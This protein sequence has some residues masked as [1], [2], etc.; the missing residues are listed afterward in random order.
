MSKKELGVL[1]DSGR[2]HWKKEEI[3]ALL[4]LIKEKGFN[5]FQWHFSDFLGFRVKLDSFPEIASD[6]HLSKEEMREI[7]TYAE[8]LGID[9]VPEFDT[10]G[11][12]TPMLAKYPTWGVKQID[13]NGEVKHSDTALD[14][15]NP[16]AKQAV[17]T[18]LE[19]ILTLFPNSTHFHLGADEFIWFSKVQE[20][21]DLISSSQALVGEV[22][23]GLESY[24]AY[25]NE[26]ID[27]MNER[28]KTPRVWNDGFFRSDVVSKVEL[29]KNVEICYWTKWDEAMATLDTWLE[30]GYKMLNYN[31]NY[32]YYVLGEHSSYTYPT[33]EKVREGWE[34]YKFSGEQMVPDAHKHQLVGTYLA[35]WSDKPE[36]KTPQEILADISPVMEVMRE[37]VEG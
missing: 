18:I 20:F 11:H 36:A 2:K 16:E 35:I 27:F 14:I 3:L 25:T 21:P 29:S 34:E 32:L 37:K 23:S 33:A 17:F 31:D 26:L 22:A 1:L 7:I 9:I 10:P 30:K 8:K 5:T 28:G 19:E 24:V 6:D 12:L 13:E 15:T 4:D